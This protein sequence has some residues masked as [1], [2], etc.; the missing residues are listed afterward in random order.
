MANK[1]E[2]IYSALASLAIYI[3]LILS[4]LVYIKTNEVKKINATVKNTVLQLDVIL[5]SEPTKEKVKIESSVKNT[6]I[7]KKVVKKT[8]STSV[9]KRTNL[10]SLFANVK[11]DIKNVSKDKVLNVKESSISSRFKSKF[12]KERKTKKLVLSKLTENKTMQTPNKNVSMEKTSE[13]QDPYYSKIYQILSS[14]WNPT[15]FVNDLKVKVNIII[16][17]NGK[18]SYKFIQYSGNVGFDNQLQ[19]FLNNETLK[20]YPVSPNNK[21]V[22][23][24][25]TFQSKG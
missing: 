5:D 12:E 22:N 21:T 10:K 7:A 23:I 11:T 13:N 1:Q 25:I 2:L 9:K 14:R 19:E 20:P 3:I 8:T 24:E 4:F 6:E 17:N 18:F 16:F 15:I